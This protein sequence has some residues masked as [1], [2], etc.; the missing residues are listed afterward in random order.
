MDA[1]KDIQNV[2]RELLNY[3]QTDFSNDPIDAA[4]SIGYLLRRGGRIM[5]YK[6]EN[7]RRRFEFDDFI[8][9]CHIVE[10]A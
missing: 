6:C 9:F 8:E 5:Q 3:V 1:I 2:S 10:K 7:C 4:K